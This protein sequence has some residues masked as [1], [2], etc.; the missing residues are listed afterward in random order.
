M[1]Q[2]YV[3]GTV[4]RLDSRSNVSKK[5]GKPFSIYSV[6]VNGTDIEVGFK[7]PYKVGDTFES[8]VEY[9]FKT[10][11]VVAGVP[12]PS[13]PPIPNSSGGTSFPS[14]PA[15]GMAESTFPISIKDGRSTSIIRQNALSNAV[16]LVN[17][18][19]ETVDDLTPSTDPKVETRARA[20]LAIEIAY[21]F[22]AFSS[23]N[24]DLEF[25]AP[26]T[27]KE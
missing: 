13:L 3:S 16:A 6:T 1:S 11:R 14:R 26:K 12:D 20:D 23:G 22:A 7:Q 8:N 9:A 4:T 19:P 27:D 5:T 10:Y 21:K 24:A 15:P 2:Y 17:S 25:L 18:L